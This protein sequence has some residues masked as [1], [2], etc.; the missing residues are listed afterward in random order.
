M[1]SEKIK[2][3]YEKYKDIEDSILSYNGNQMIA[4][5]LKNF[6]LAIKQSLGHKIEVPKKRR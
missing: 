4:E 1:K 2:E 3:V 6:W 5:M